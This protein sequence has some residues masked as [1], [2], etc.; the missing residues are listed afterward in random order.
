M[1]EK[2][3]KPA[4]KCPRC[5][6]DLHFDVVQQIKDE[7]RIS[8]VIHPKESGAMISAGTFGGTVVQFEKMMKAFSREVGVKE[9]VLVERL[10]TGDDGS[11]RV[12]FLVCRIKP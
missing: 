12:D 4:P 5:G 3:D 6:T 10:S 7:S 1:T 2:P 11:L 8:W 9:S